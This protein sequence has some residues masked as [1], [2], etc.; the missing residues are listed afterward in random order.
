VASASSAGL[1]LGF[2]VLIRLTSTSAEFLSSAG[3]LL[4]I[5]LTRAPL[6]VPLTAFQGAAVTYFLRNRRRGLTALLKV[7]GALLVVTAVAAGVAALVGP[8]LYTLLLGDRY[9]VGGLLLG[10]LTVGAG[11]LAVI[12]LTGTC[13][14]ALGGHRGYA[15]GWVLAVATALLLLL[16][17]AS[18][19][20]RAVVTLACAPITGIA[21]HF[22][23]VG[24]SVARVPA[25]AGV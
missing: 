12:T 6:L 22:W 15:L 25:T 16:M 5:M 13:C 20:V 18:L 9:A 17:P 7:T 24:R 23:S 1:V 11:M 14:L 10:G 2:P 21:V 19:D 3:L 4:A 8:W